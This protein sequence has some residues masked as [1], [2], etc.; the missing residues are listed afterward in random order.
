MTAKADT[1]PLA[2][3]WT[4]TRALGIRLTLLDDET[5][6][7]GASRDTFATPE[8]A[9]RWCAE[10]FRQQEAQTHAQIQALEQRANEHRELAEM[11]DRQALNGS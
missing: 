1:H 3:L 10:Q 8:A 11:L 5:I 7:V 6:S 2:I 9:I 4:A